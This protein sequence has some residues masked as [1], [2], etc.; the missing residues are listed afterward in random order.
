[1]GILDNLAVSWQNILGFMPQNKVYVNRQKDKN[2]SEE[3]ELLSCL[4]NCIK[5]MHIASQNFDEAYNE[6]LVDYY[7]YELKAAEIRYQYILKSIKERGIEIPREL[8]VCLER[9]GPR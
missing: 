8:M 2:V 1:M 3:K 7:T 9:V 4:R 5:D 6:D